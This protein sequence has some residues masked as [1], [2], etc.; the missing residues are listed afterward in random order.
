MKQGMIALAHKLA[1]E[2]PQAK[3]I[4]QIHDELLISVP[5][6]QCAQ[7]EKITKN[8]LET[9]VDWN[10]PLEVTIRN[11]ASWADVTK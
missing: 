1:T 11:G 2:L 6:A 9:I 7:A 4:L 8:V 3:L 5:A 10:V